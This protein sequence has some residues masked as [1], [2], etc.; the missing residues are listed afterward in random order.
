MSK[1][2]RVFFD[3]ACPLCEREISLYKDADHAKKIDWIDVSRA[4]NAE[5]LPLPVQ[6]LLARFH[7]QTPDGELIGGAR[8]FIE[9][10]RHLPRWRWLARICSSPGVPS[11]L[12]LGYRGFLKIRPAIQRAFRR[13]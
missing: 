8:G 3:G 11:A 6:A 13:K 4:N 5:H 7:V 1:R 12:E 9:M 10:W 2:L